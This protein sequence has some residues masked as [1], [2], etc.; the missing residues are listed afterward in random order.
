MRSSQDCGSVPSGQLCCERKQSGKQSEN[1]TSMILLRVVAS[2]VASCGT[3]RH[4]PNQSN[5]ILTHAGL[6]DSDLDSPQSLSP[7][8]Q[9]IE[10][11]AMQCV[12]CYQVK[13]PHNHTVSQTPNPGPLKC[14]YHTCPTCLHPRRLGGLASGSIRRRR[15]CRRNNDAHRFHELA[16]QPDTNSDSLLPMRCSPQCSS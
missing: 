3:N 15:S 8:A 4:E 2:F 9:S 16:C 7:E 6:V 10:K 14:T 11:Q 12:R 5:T 1:E 13:Q